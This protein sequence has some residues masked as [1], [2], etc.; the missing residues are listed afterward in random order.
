MPDDRKTRAAGLHFFPVESR[1]D[2]Q[3]IETYLDV[4]DL[5]GIGE[6]QTFSSRFRIDSETGN[7]LTCGAGC[8]GRILESERE[9]VF[10]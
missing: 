6:S 8:K 7:L 9:L 2:Y 3:I 4:C 10:T 5:P 1:L